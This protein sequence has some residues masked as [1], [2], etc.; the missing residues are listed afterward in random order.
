MENTQDD[1]LNR[2]FLILWINAFNSCELYWCQ[3]SFYHPGLQR[4]Y[5]ILFLLLPTIC[6][7]RVGR[8]VLG[9]CASGAVFT[10]GFDGL[11][12]EWVKHASPCQVC[13]IPHDAACYAA[14]R[15]HVSVLTGRPERQDVRSA[16]TLVLR[17]F[18]QAH[19]RNV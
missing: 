4:L 10:M 18:A 13:L 15:Q 3:A 6:D 16:R 14:F 17:L 11:V 2:V 9:A 1:I 19:R 5:G 12:V 8:S 7:K